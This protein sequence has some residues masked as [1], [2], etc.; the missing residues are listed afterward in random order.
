MIGMAEKCSEVLLGFECHHE[1]MGEAL[2]KHLLA[3]NVLTPAMK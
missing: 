2:S 3:F 1:G